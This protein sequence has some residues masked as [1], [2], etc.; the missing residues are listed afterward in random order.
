MVKYTC[1]Q[2]KSLLLTIAIQMGSILKKRAFFLALKGRYIP[3]QGNALG[4]ALR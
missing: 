2:N 4:M 1:L 3:A